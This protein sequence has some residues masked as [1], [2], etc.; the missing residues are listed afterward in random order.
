MLETF[1]DI[2]LRY[3]LLCNY[4]NLGYLEGYGAAKLLLQLNVF[5]GINLKVVKYTY[6]KKIVENISISSGICSRHWLDW[7][8]F[9]SSG[10]YFYHI[11][12]GCVNINI[13]KAQLDPWG[14]PWGS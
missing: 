3:F 2:F 8:Q 1:V 10:I 11:C 12:V 13:V 7:L 6:K 9:G 5:F 14:P 4:S